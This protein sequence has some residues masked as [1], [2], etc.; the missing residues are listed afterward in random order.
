M[1]DDVAD[2]VELD[3]SEFPAGAYL[4]AVR[5]RDRLRYETLILID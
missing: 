4:L 5:V 1:E 2:K 3:Y